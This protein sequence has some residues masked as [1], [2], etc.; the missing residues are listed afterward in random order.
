MQYTQGISLDHL[1]KYNYFI[2]NE[3]HRT[4]QKKKKGEYIIDVFAEDV[5]NKRIKCPMTG[6]SMVIEQYKK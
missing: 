5:K 3:Y 6:K 2:Q 1:P 4:Q